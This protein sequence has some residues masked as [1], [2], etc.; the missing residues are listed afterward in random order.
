M[1]AYES[2]GGRRS[3]ISVSPPTRAADAVFLVATTYFVVKL[4]TDPDLGMTYSH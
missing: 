4:E 2:G 1:N 3:T